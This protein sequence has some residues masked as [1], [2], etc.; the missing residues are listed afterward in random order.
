MFDFFGFLTFSG[1]IEMKNLVEMDYEKLNTWLLL[2]PCE[3]LVTFK[4]SYFQNTMDT[5]NKLNVC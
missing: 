3:L 5:Q 4:R 2:P 1:G